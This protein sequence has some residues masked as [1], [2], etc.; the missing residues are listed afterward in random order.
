MSTVNL[1][2]TDSFSEQFA[3]KIK[4]VVFSPIN[5]PS[6][7]GTVH[8][9]VIFHKEMDLSHAGTCTTPIVSSKGLCQAVPPEK[10]YAADLFTLSNDPLKS[11]NGVKFFS[12]PHG[13]DAGQV[14]GWY[15]IL[16]NKIT[17]NPIYSVDPNT[18]TYLWDGTAVEDGYAEYCKTVKKCPQ[19]IQINGSYLVALYTNKDSN[20][21]TFNLDVPNLLAQPIIASRNGELNNITIIPIARTTFYKR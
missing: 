12:A 8:Y 15:N 13:W 4:S 9:G 20:C 16:P 11:G 3:G 6:A 17:S 18:M 19:S 21:Q 7:G 5:N 2:S 10:A 1:A 14:A